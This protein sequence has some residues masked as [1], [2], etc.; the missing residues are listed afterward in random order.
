[1]AFPGGSQPNGWEWTAAKGNFGYG[2]TCRQKKMRR[3]HREA[4]RFFGVTIPDGLFVLHDCD[5][6]PCVNPAHLTI[7]TAKENTQDSKRKRR[8][9]YG[10]RNGMAVLTE[11][12]VA[13]LRRR[14]DSGERRDRLAVD[15]G[16]GAKHASKIA[17]RRA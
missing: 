17:N 1:V 5:N 12:Q 3:A 8:N 6:P 14:A 15:F 10:Q 11:A 4:L 13:E 2:V 7:G 16:I 9:N